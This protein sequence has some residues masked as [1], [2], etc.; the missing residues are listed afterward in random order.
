VIWPVPYLSRRGVAAYAAVS[1]LVCSGPIA[2]VL[3]R[4]KG[5]NMG[6][7]EPR[8]SAHAGLGAVQKPLV[9]TSSSPVIA[10]GDHH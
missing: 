5:L 7:G 1:G 8:R 10:V 2:V 3:E 4:A 9:T 6:R